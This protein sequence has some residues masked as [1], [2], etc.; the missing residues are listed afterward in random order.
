MEFCEDLIVLDDKKGADFASLLKNNAILLDHK[1]TDKG[2]NDN[3]TEKTRRMEE[4]YGSSI[5]TSIIERK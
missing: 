4:N 5:L 3:K 1:E 2:L